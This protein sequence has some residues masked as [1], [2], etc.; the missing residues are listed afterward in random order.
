M[1]TVNP[2][3]QLLFDK[4]ISPSV[5]R[6]AIMD[7]LMRY[8]SHP[9]VDE[10]YKSLSVSI[11]TLSKTTVYNTLTLFFSVGLIDCFQTD[12]GTMHYDATVIHHAHFKCRQCGKIFD[13]PF[14]IIDNPLIED[15]EVDDIKVM[16]YGI[17]KSCKQFC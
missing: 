6:T 14:P 8:Q 12:D 9:T 10:I 7:Y 15:F 5:Q 2:V 4:G 3:S 11:P 17:C 1:P 16:Y 13:L